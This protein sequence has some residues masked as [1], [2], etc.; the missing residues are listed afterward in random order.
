MEKQRVAAS[1][2]AC[3]EKPRYV[4]EED[5]IGCGLCELACPIDVPHEFDYGLGARRAI[6][7]PHGNAIP[8]K[9]V[10][11]VEHCIFCGKCEKACPT[12]CIDFSQEP[13]EVTTSVGTVIIATGLQDHADGRQEGVR[14][15]QASPT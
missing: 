5:C 4:V 10:L 8:Q 12:H 15:R 3:S 6:Y 11:D 2:C 13:E 9:A 14:R 7:I 1:R